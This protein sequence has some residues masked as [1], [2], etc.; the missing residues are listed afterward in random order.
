VTDSFLEVWPEPDV[1]QGQF[2]I[3][4][5]AP[6]GASA[7]CVK[8]GESFAYGPRD[9]DDTPVC[10]VLSASAQTRPRRRSMMLVAL[11]PTRPRHAVCP[12]AP[13][14]V[15]EIE[16][17]NTGERSITFD[18][19]IERDNPAL[20]DAGPR[21][22]SYFV[23]DREAPGCIDRGRT[24]NSVATGAATYVVGGYYGRGS[25]FH[26]HDIAHATS[27]SRYSSS[28]PG[29]ELDLLDGPD[30]GAPADES[31]VLHG[32]CATGNRSG[33]AF[34]MDGTSVAAPLMARRVA[35]TLALNQKPGK[36]PTKTAVLKALAAGSVPAVDPLRDGD[37][38]IVPGM[39]P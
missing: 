29:R 26:D 10:A 30:V 14:G 19:W 24:L 38:R 5:R 16:V 37:F 21:R 33:T 12:A 9:P 18:A 13:H 39:E 27:V 11:A 34:R 4:L 25:F 22:Q 23:D 6:G 3:H 1:R 17:R 2:E 20:G 15:W 28:G 35:N 32:L 31:P 36:P 8:L 7:Q